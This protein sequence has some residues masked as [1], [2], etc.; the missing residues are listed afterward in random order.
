MFQ[1]K[2]FSVLAISVSDDYLN[3]NK[4]FED[5]KPF[6]SPYLPWFVKF[7]SVCLFFN[8]KK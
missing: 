8:G 1:P 6:S 7:K 4:T 3:Q 5:K 2:Y